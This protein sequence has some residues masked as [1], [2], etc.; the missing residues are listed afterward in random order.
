V[1]AVQAYL[2]ALVRARGLPPKLLVLHQFVEPMLSHPEQYAAYR[3]VELTI[4]MDGYGTVG[5]K[6][7]HYQSFALAPYA[8][9]AAIKLFYD[10]DQPLLPPERIQALDRPPDL[11][12]YQ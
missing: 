11:V 3:E 10:W 4:D 9:R 6:L 12:I 1:N 2:A 7:K 5:G 8:E